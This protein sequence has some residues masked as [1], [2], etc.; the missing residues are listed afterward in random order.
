MEQTLTCTCCGKDFHPLKFYRGKTP[1][2][3]ECFSPQKRET[4]VILNKAFGGFDFSDGFIR[5]LATKSYINLDSIRVGNFPRHHPGI[6]GE[7]KSYGSEKAT[8]RASLLEIELATEG[9]YYI[10]EYEGLESLIQPSDMVS[11]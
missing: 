10:K 9:K 3:F 8:G 6:I 1:K 2:C 5:Y 11:F 7:F 4:E